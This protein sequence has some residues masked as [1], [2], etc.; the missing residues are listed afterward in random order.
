MK[1]FV[2]SLIFI[3]FFVSIVSAQ[4]SPT[5]LEECSSLLMS[6]EG[7]SQTATEDQMNSLLSSVNPLCMKSVEFSEWVNEILY[8]YLISKPSLFV[9]VLR[10]QEKGIQERIIEEI[11]NPVHDGIDLKLAHQ[12]VGDMTKDSAEKNL[13]SNAILYAAKNLGVYIEK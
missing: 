9:K 5:N 10:K 2:I 8:S 1:K 11:K 6:L 3:L 13:I 7:S 4:S 12:K